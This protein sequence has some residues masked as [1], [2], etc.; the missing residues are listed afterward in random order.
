M[1]TKKIIELVEGTADAAFAVDEG[2]LVSAWNKAAEN[3]FGPTS[4]QAIGK[5]CHE[6]I[7]GADE[8]DLVCSEQCVRFIRQFTTTDRP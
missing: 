5:R 8:K 7:Q 3:L 6:I 1:D 2:G 4:I